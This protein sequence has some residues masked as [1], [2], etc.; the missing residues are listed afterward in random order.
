MLQER[1]RQNEIEMKIGL[2]WINKVGILLILFGVGAAAQ[3][4]HS[5]WFNDYMRGASF[6]LLGGA[7]LAGGE[8]MY[9]NGKR[10]FSTGLLGGGAAI[11]YGSVFYSYFLLNIINLYAGLFISVL[12]TFC[13]VVLS[14]RY[15]SKTI[16]SLGLVGGYLPFFT[17]MMVYGIQRESC[18]IAM[19]YLLLLNLS[20][21]GISYRKKWDIVNYLGMLLHIPSMI[22]LAFCADSVWIAMI[23]TVVGFA[24]HLLA[25]LAYPLH[26]AI[27]IRKHDLILIGINT[28]LSCTVLYGLLQK[29]GLSD[30]NGLL[31]LVFCLVYAQFGK[32]IEK[33]IPTEIFARLIFYAVSL[34]FAV[35]MI[36]FQLGI[37]WMSMGWLV[38]SVVFI[39]YGLKHKEESLEKAGWGILLFCLG[40]FYLVDFLLYY[41][42]TFYLYDFMRPASA[43]FDYKFTAITLGTIAV[44]IAYVKNSRAD[45]MARYGHFWDL[46]VNFKYFAIV[47]TWLYLQYMSGQIYSA[48]MPRNEHFILYERMLMAAINVG[49]AY[50]I[51]RVPSLCGKGARII[52]YLFYAL[53]VYLCALINL[54]ISVINNVSAMSGAEYGAIAAL[55]VFNV[56]MVMVFSELLIAVIKKQRLAFEFYPMG[57][58]LYLL[59]NVTVVLFKQFHLGAGH[60]VFSFVILFTALVSLIYG[61]RKG[62]IYTRRFGLGLSIFSTAKLFLFDLRFLE[63]FHKI[64]AYFVFGFVLLGISYLYQRLKSRAEGGTHDQ[65]M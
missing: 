2:N 24:I 61:F 40:A 46:A 31:A 57:I 56:C 36:P 60:I 14:L 55:V 11:L 37:R 65:N 25:Q 8:W 42:S 48:Y 51:C 39:A 43:Y 54:K 5:T 30:Y 59:G 63:N 13:M 16:C 1:V 21:L 9:R 6:F 38:E 23:Y 41:R 50:G 32:Y 45:G 10:I 3:Y 64:I 18:Y 53:S 7:F 33:K 4:A 20:V 22:V 12:I 17:F 19:L 62:Y 44:A 26:Y 34:T 49:M 15:H 28:F 52:A 27:S 58:I 35:L 47:N 29:G